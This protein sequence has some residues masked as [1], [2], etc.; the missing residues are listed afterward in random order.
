M[1]NWRNIRFFRT[2]FPFELRFYA[3]HTLTRTHNLSTV[4]RLLHNMCIF[5]NKNETKK[6]MKVTFDLDIYNF[7]HSNNLSINVAVAA[8][9]KRR[10]K[11]ISWACMFP[12]RS[13]WSLAAVIIVYQLLSQ[14]FPSFF[15][16]LHTSTMILIR[17]SEASIWK[18]LCCV[19]L[20]R[21]RNL[22][23]INWC[24]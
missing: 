10:K 8:E 12:L 11:T 14:T 7:Q 16:S 17:I 4:D 13:C 22:L 2:I 24:N 5:S 6:L 19:F 1:L 3:E 15:F 9:E 21:R 23:C 20:C 18:R